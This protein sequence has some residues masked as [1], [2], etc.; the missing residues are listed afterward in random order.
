MSDKKY[1]VFEIDDLRQVMQ[2]K[3]LWGDYNGPPSDPQGTSLSR[4]YNEA[5][6]TKTVEEWVRTAMLAGH[7]AEDYRNPSQRS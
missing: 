5:D 7:T 3:Y 4:S 6:K 1:S 2:N